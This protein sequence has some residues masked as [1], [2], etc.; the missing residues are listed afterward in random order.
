MKKILKLCAVACAAVVSITA[1]A[2]PSYVTTSGNGAAGVTNYFAAQPLYQARIV[3]AIA[4]SDKAGSFIQLSSGSTACTVTNPISCSTN[5]GGTIFMVNATN[6]LTVGDILVLQTANGTNAAGVA[7]GNATGVIA[8]LATNN[9]TLASGGFNCTMAAGDEVF[10]MGTASKFPLGASL[11]NYQGDALFVGA[12][13]RP[14]RIVIDGTS[15]CTN[16]S[17]TARYE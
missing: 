1:W 17:T 9:V 6:G 2:Q 3:G 13:G 7:V 4:Q 11:Q 12:K 5:S 15:A 14:I 16:I 10:K 8:A